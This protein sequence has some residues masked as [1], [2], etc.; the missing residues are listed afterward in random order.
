MTDCGLQ[1][2]SAAARERRR[3]LHF[4]NRI[5]TRTQPQSAPG[6][7]TARAQLNDADRPTPTHEWTK[8]APVATSAASLIN[9]PRLQQA[10]HPHNLQRSAICAEVSAPSST[11]RTYNAQNNSPVAKPQ[12]VRPRSPIARPPVT[13]C[14]GA[15]SCGVHRRSVLQAADLT[16]SA[17]RHML[18]SLALSP[19]PR[20]SR[21][22]AAGL[23]RVRDSESA[24]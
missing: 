5:A 21:R 3:W 19:G 18:T 4:A 13:Q 10:T 17:D 2:S 9:I 15:S 20:S 22:A 6:V 14:L 16:H 1:V 7:R 11:A 23:A 24:L 12:V 8:V